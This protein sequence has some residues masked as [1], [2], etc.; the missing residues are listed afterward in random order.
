V[1]PG[2]RLLSR[3]LRGVLLEIRQGLAIKFLQRRQGSGVAFGIEANR[4][5]IQLK[6]GAARAKAQILQPTALGT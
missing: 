6:D 3:H 4:A 1:R 5:P 2:R